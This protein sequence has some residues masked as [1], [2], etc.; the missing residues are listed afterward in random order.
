M[1][2]KSTNVDLGT[3]LQNAEVGRKI[4]NEVSSSSGP[5]RP[6]KVVRKAPKR[7]AERVIPSLSFTEETGLSLELT[8]VG[9]TILYEDP[10]KLFSKEFNP[11]LK[12][13]VP[14]LSLANKALNGIPYDERHKVYAK[15]ANGRPVKDSPQLD[16][17]G[18]PVYT[19]SYLDRVTHDL[20]IILS[21][22]ACRA[23]IS[24]LTDAVAKHRDEY[25][26]PEFKSESPYMNKV[27]SV[28]SRAKNT[29]YGGYDR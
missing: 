22:E 10:K 21:D 16:G 9:N 11:L 27:K 18:N 26:T 23:A 28:P 29:S 7:A 12:L 6:N 13:M 20:R 8:H 2:Q 15:D 25:I 4:Q 19:Q 17:Y 5:K 14:V 3:A 1:E 24:S